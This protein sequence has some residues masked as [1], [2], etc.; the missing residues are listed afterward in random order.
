MPVMEGAMAINI[1]IGVYHLGIKAR[2]KPAKD[3]L[4]TFVPPIFRMCARGQECA[5]DLYAC[6]SPHSHISINFWGISEL[7]RGARIQNM[8]FV[9]GNI[10]R[11]DLGARESI[12][13][14]DQDFHLRRAFAN[15]GELL[16]QSS[17]PLHAV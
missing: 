12:E 14:N 6:E 5:L 4:H 13:V 2:W 15:H 10:I 17:V 3:H 16:R 11:H 7:P 9:V 1:Q 8:F